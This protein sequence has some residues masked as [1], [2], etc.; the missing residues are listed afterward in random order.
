MNKI[1]LEVQNL[2]VSFDQEKILSD[3]SFDVTKGEVLVIL[4]PNGAG[5]TTL[6]KALLG[7][8]PYTGKV[9]WKNKK[10]SYLPPQ[11]LFVRKDL[12]PLS[13]QD[14]FEF[15][16]VSK[17]KIIEFLNLVGLDPS[18]L[19]K[20]FNTLSTG[21][22]QRMVI[23]WALIDEP[24]ILLFDEPTSGIDLGGEETIYSLLHKFWKEKKL[25]ILLVTHDLNIVWDHASNVLCL[26]KKK[27]C[28]GKPDK[29]LSPEKLKEL[30]HSDVKFY[31]HEH[32]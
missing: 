31:S 28:M 23:A 5:K 17:S 21:Q 15:K 7:L 3:L 13:I 19:T 30:Y 11:E 10:I 27:L 32:N 25:T 18:I 8:V 4:G 29:I 12:P 9:E 22:F 24:S 6:L 26:N 16:N 20:Q 14:F 1:I 2:S